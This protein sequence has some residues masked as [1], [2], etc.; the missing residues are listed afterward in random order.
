MY[1]FCLYTAHVYM[2]SVIIVA[3]WFFSELYGK[4]KDFG[5]NLHVIVPKSL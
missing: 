4:K 2:K 1:F 3:I 5:L